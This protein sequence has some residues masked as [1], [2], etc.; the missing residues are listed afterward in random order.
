MLL[1]L[2]YYGANYMLLGALFLGIGAQANNIREIQTM[3]M[4]ITLL[5]DGV[6]FLALT[7]V[8]SG[9]DWLAWTAYLFPFSSPLTMIAFAAEQ[10]T[11]W[12]HL[13]ALAWQALWIV[14]IIRVS[15][16]LFRMTVLKSATGRILLRLPA[17]SGGAERLTLSSGRGRA[18]L[19]PELDLDAVAIEDPGE[20]AIILVLPAQYLDPLGLEVGDHAVE[21]VDAQID[22]EPGART[23]PYSR[24]DSLN[25]LNRL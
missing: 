3:T 22:H 2:L 14:L 6:F 4:P 13:L 1:V 17:P 24:S 11:L 9:N 23:E 16:R 21:I 5:Q 19:L 20:I 18:L 15:S 12:P 10:A 7:V 8:G 25:G